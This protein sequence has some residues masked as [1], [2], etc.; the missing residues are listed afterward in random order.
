MR[1]IK[2]GIFTT[3]FWVTT[4]AAIATYVAPFI[5]PTTKAIIVAA[6]GA[7]YVIGRTI[8]KAFGGREP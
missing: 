1:S 6:G 3:E 4:S 8:V 5:P 2:P 7:I